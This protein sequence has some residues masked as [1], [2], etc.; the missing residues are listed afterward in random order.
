MKPT[1]YSITVF[2]GDNGL[3]LSVVSSRD[4]HGTL[5]LS[6]VVS[7]LDSFYHARDSTA[8]ITKQVR[9]EVSDNKYAYMEFSKSVDNKIGEYI[10][11]VNIKPKGVFTKRNRHDECDFSISDQTLYCETYFLF[12]N[13]NGSNGSDHREAYVKFMDPN[14]SKTKRK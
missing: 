11:S 7:S 9:E 12:F 2:K 3:S 6:D 1:V 10:G 8:R 4:A 13:P 5:E 14:G